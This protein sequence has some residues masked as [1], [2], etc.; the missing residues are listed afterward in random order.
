VVTTPIE[1]F[2]S[3]ANKDKKIAKK[4]ADELNNYGLKVFVAHEDIEVGVKWEPTLFVKIKE[5]DLFVAILSENFHSA[6]YTDHEVGIAYGLHKLLFP[7]RID[8]TMPYGFMSKFQAK[9]ISKDIDKDEITKLFFK[10]VATSE[11]GVEMVNKLI[12]EFRIS[13]SFEKA[14][15]NADIL[16]QYSKFSDEQLKQIAE[17]FVYNDQIREG[18][19]SGRWCERLLKDNWK[20]LDKSIQN[21]LEQYL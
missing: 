3:H 17:A 2:L 6:Q 8:D 18:F 13:N 4:L 21:K 14:N 20:L 12:E 9:K 10:M 1:I 19:R 15:H 5:C 11:K 7:I 16:S